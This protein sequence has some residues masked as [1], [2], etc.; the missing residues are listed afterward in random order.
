[1]KISK[2]IKIIF[3]TM[4]ILSLI[5][6]ASLYLLFNGIKER[7]KA[8]NAQHEYTHLAEDF[9]DATNLLMESVRTYAQYGKKE[10]YD[11][12]WNEVNELKTREN[13]IARL[14]ELN[15]PKEIIELAQEALNESLALSQ[16]E[17]DSMKAVERKNFE[18][19]R[20]LVFGDKYEKQ[21]NKISTI[22]NEF[23]EKLND[24]IQSEE[25]KSL[26][27]MNLYLT[28]TIVVIVVMIINIINAI[29]ILRHKIK[30]LQQLTNVANLIA[31]GDLT[32]KPPIPKRAKDEVADL[33]KSINFMIDNL[34]ALIQQIQQTAEQVAAS[35]EELLASSEQSTKASEDVTATIEQLSVGAEQQVHIVDETAEIISQLSTSTEQIA[36]RTDNVIGTTTNAVDKAKEGNESIQH[37]VDQMNDINRSVQELS[38][39]IVSLNDHSKEIGSIVQVI[40]G[41]AEQTNLLALNAAIE[42]ARA[43][44]NGKGFAV[45]ADEVRKLAEQSGESA[46]QISELIETIQSETNRAVD[47]MDTTSKE[48]DKG[49]EIIHS[50]GILFKHIQD[51]FHMAMTQIEE[52]AAS[53]QQMAAGTAQVVHST[54]TV[55]TVA[56]ETSAG[57]Q[58]VSA[59]SEEQL[60]SMEE[61]THAAHSLAKMAED[62]QTQL[63]RFKY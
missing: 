10:Y 6:S 42:A 60:A 24:Y 38:Q 9:V 58:T 13:V 5:S 8:T 14:T 50:A 61:I 29:L 11:A 63:G 25:A 12:Y 48:V 19:A 23:N 1:M 43:G 37:S 17:S 16:V 39:V 2:I 3:I 47:S 41:I 27:K 54:H 20:F 26:K 36:H 7:E 44:E 34:Q 52:V 56:N 31:K 46:K 49:K 55:K 22:L 40:T 33:T 45:V 53:V 57:A 32:T 30:P 51:S 15:V 35:S 21:K 4:I 28:I 18:N 59:A 62:L